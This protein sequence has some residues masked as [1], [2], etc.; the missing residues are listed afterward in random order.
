MKIKAWGGQGVWREAAQGASPSVGQCWYSRLSAA[1]Y[2][3]TEAEVCP[4]VGGM[5]PAF[6]S[7]A[8]L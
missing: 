5:V 6:L 7:I 1:V 4:A 8:G 2:R 3:G